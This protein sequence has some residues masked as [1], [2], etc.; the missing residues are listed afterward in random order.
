MKRLWDWFKS[1]FGDTRPICHYCDGTG[2]V[3]VTES[4]AA[5]CPRCGGTGEYL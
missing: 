4:Y 1:W 5:R 2:V 3:H